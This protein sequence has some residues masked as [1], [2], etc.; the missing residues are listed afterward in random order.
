MKLSGNVDNE[1]WISYLHCGEVLNYHY[2]Y[3]CGNELLG[4]GLCSPK[5]FLV[6]Q[7]NEREGGLCS[8]LTLVRLVKD[9]EMTL[10]SVHPSS[11][12]ESSGVDEFS[13]MLSAES[14]L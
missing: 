9:K 14:L 12:I 6:Q 2:L 8:P 5:V 3:C 1:K 11:G 4:S 10:V 7:T 13:A